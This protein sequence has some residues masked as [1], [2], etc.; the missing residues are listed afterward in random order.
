MRC[1]QRIERHYYPVLPPDCWCEYSGSRL[2]LGINLN[3]DSDTLAAPN[4]RYS[5][6]KP[7]GLLRTRLGRSAALGLCRKRPP[8]VLGTSYSLHLPSNLIFLLPP[9]SALQHRDLLT[10]RSRN[11][12]NM[13]WTVS[14]CLQP[15]HRRHMRDSPTVASF[16]NDW[17]THDL[18]SLDE[19]VGTGLQN[20]QKRDGRGV[21][22]LRV[23]MLCGLCVILFC[24]ATEEPNGRPPRVVVGPCFVIRRSLGGAVERRVAC[25]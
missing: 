22:H 3:P 18:P 23:F 7:A 2:R 4:C 10:P 14:P 12:P 5:V 19:V 11:S 1:L 6:R 8:H 15:R 13:A 21:K 25:L 20:S 9:D 16:L 24:H 17:Y